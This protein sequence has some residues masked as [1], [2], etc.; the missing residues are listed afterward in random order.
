MGDLM[1]PQQ[2]PIGPVSVTASK[3]ASAEASR[4]ELVHASP[5]ESGKTHH[6]DQVVPRV[7]PENERAQLFAEI[8]W[9]VLQPET[10]LPSSERAREASSQA[11]SITRLGRSNHSESELSSLGSG[12]TR[13]STSSVTDEPCQDIQ[14][15][16]EDLASR[17]VFRSIFFNYQGLITHAP[18][19]YGF[20]GS[21]LGSIAEVTH[22]TRKSRA[23][24]RPRRDC[25]EEDHI[26]EGEDED[27]DGDED[28]NKDRP[29]N[30]KRKRK[31]P[32]KLV[33][34]FACPFA[35]FDPERYSQQNHEE[36][37]YRKCSSKCLRNI[38]RLKQHLYRVHKRPEWYC[39]NCYQKFIQRENLN[40]HNR[41]RPPC[42]QNAARYEEKMTDDQYKAIKRRSTGSD[43]C[44]TW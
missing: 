8:F 19:P 17:I 36:Q 20:T 14:T 42:D 21:G 31:S 35:K 23:S 28:G 22:V 4:R 15:F 38:T 30:R 27:E 9:S 34:L 44:E 40:K 7:D 24:K 16:S 41:E 18:V 13:W 32:E 25:D 39:S 1:K 37:S 29:P 12:M 43:P 5:G 10:P 11:T 33:K 3:P 2:T 6:D 26:S